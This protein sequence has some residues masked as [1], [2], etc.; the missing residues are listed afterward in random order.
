MHEAHEQMAPQHSIQLT[1]VGLQGSRT[2]ALK[3]TC[4]VRRI[5]VFM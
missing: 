1:D 2:H 3:T 5:C 4:Q